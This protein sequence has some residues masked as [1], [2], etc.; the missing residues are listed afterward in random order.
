MAEG[1]QD[2]QK[3]AEEAGSSRTGDR[4]KA[5]ETGSS[6]TFEARQKDLRAAEEQI[7][8]GAVPQ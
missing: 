5:E 4:E 7:R 3:K 8:R 2:D 1:R 6:R